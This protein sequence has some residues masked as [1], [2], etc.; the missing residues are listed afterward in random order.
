MDGEGLPWRGDPP[1][2][3]DAFGSLGGKRHGACC[4]GLLGCGAIPPLQALPC[5]LC[6]PA[7]QVHFDVLH[8]SRCKLLPVARQPCFDLSLNETRHML[9]Q[10]PLL[11][12]RCP[13]I[14]LRPCGGQD[15]RVTC[16]CLLGR[17]HDVK[18]KLLKQRAKLGLRAKGEFD[19][20]FGHPLPV[21]RHLC[22]TPHTN[23][24]DNCT[25]IRIVMIRGLQTKASKG[26]QRTKVLPRVY[27]DG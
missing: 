15:P 22:R 26:T 3:R 2:Q 23:S 1:L 13:F 10:R 27:R 6:L 16:L 18:S 9:R 5:F 24:G 21:G 17:R 14:D 7:C 11:S 19:W 25:M 8:D 12:K 4:G 20:E